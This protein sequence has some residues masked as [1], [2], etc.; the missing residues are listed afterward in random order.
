MAREAK[1]LSIERVV[2]H[3]EHAIRVAGPRHVGIGS[4]FDGILNGPQGLEDATCYPNLLAALFERG[5]DEETVAGV[6]GANFERV[7]RAVTD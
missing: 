3:V 5:F 1:P 2:D 4:D 6:T 7:F